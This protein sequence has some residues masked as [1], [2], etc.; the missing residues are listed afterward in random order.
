MLIERKRKM[1]I[2]FGLS[3]I[4]TAIT[5]GLYSKNGISMTDKQKPIYIRNDENFEHYFQMF[6]PNELAK[7]RKFWLIIYLGENWINQFSSGCILWCV[8]SLFD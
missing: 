7:Q 8:I 4:S 6:H 3:S 5:F 2:T 1:R